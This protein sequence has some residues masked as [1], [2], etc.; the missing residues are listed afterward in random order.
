VH[1]TNLHNYA[2]IF[3]ARVFVP[4]ESYAEK[5]LYY[6]CKMLNY[7]LIEQ[8]ERFGIDDV[9]QISRNSLETFFQN[10]ALKT[11]ERWKLSRQAASRA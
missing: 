6:V 8:Y 4:L 11:K 5:K 10:Y 2:G 3:E 9:L 1:F 7:V